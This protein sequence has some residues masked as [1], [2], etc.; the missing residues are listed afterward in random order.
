ARADRLDLDLGEARA[1]TRVLA[2]TGALLVLADPDLL[3]E[4]VAHDARRDCDRGREVGLA[5]AADEQHL[6]SERLALVGLEPVHQQPLALMDAVLLA[7]ESDDRVAHS[8]EN[9]GAERPRGR[10]Q[11]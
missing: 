4:L 6:R 8:V 3:A 2:V 11:C 1:E 10:R 5:V 9:A 7:T